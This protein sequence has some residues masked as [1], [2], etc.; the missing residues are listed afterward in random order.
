[1]RLGSLFSGIE[2]FGL[3]A[4][5]LGIETVFSCEIDSFCREVIRKNFSK[6]TIYEDI[7]KTDF[8]QYRGEIDILTG[9][10]PCQPFS[11]AGQRKGAGDDRYLWPEML[12]VIDEVRPTWVIGENV[13]GITSMVQPCEVISV[14]NHSDLFGEDNY[15]I[16]TER[17]EYVIETVCRDLE[18]IGYSVQPFIIPACAVGAPHRRDR[19]KAI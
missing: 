15:T 2:G 18:G 16:E 14:E 1:M 6:T 7:R 5:L 19:D 13:A 17:A 10:F 4:K 8:I 11:V 9:G 12:R 3:A